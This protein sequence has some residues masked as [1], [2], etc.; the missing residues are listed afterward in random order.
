MLVHVFNKQ[1]KNMH[2]GEKSLRQ[3]TIDCRHALA[4]RGDLTASLTTFFLNKII[5][6]NICLKLLKDAKRC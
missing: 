6:K 4:K 2:C 5:Y 3:F 1:N